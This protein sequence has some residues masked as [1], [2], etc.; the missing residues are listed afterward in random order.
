VHFVNALKTNDNQIAVDLVLEG[1]IDNPK[2]SVRE[3][4]ATRL[5]VGLA[6]TLGLSVIETGG[7]VIIQSGRIMKRVGDVIKQIFK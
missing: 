3:N 5:A 1:S 4:M 2:F 6:K 7:T